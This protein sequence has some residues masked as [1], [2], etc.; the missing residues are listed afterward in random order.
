[1]KAVYVRISTP[2]QNVERQL[3]KDKSIKTYIDI[4][5]GAVPFN[6]RTNASLMMKNK[7]ISQIEV[8]E[9]SRLGRNLKDIL[10]TIEFFI[11]KGVDIRIEN[12]GLNLMVEGKISPMANLMVSMFGAIAEHERNIIN[13]RTQEGR[14]I[15]KAKGKFKGRKRGAVSNINKKNEMLI[16]WL[17]TKLNEGVSISEISKQSNNITEK[18]V[19]R[20]RIYDY[21][22]RGLIKK[23]TS[24]KAS[25]NE[26]KLLKY[27]EL[28]ND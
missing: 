27:V 2:N 20:T 14:E 8:K 13:E 7:N 5:S 24:D 11:N 6:E 15:A 18:G 10:N 9:I 12:L 17:Q 26:S 19:S 4:C 25:S 28:S 3:K 16:T 23:T 1:M 21:L 22:K